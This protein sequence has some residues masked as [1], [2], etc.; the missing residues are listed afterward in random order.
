[1]RVLCVDLM[2]DRTHF[3]HV[4]VC[5]KVFFPDVISHIWI[6]GQWT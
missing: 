2:K 3:V 1:M 5:W 4:T 6:F